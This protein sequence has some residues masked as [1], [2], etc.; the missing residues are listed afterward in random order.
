MISNY[1]YVPQ[2]IDFLVIQFC[3]KKLKYIIHY[4]KIS[5]NKIFL[6]LQSLNKKGICKKCIC[7]HVHIKFYTYI[8]EP[9]QISSYFIYNRKF[10]KTIYLY[11]NY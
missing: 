5:K 8:F 2:N 10:I 3:I 7:T 6:S 9:C 11:K 4:H 1:R